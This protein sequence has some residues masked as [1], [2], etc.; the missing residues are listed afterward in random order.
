MGA[1]IASVF[2][3]AGLEVVAI[4]RTPETLDAGIG[5]ISKSLAAAVKRGAI[6]AAEAERRRA[7]ITPE[8]RL[9]AVSEVDLV[10]EA[11]S[12]DMAIKHGIF[13]EAGRLAPSGAILATN[14]SYLDIDALA[15]A[16]GRAPDVCGMHFF[17]PASAMRLVEVIRGAR[18]A[19]DVLATMMSL[20]RRIGKLPILAGTCEGF[21]VNRLL[22]KRSR[23]GFFM[24]E[25]G[26]SPDRIDRVLQGF[27]FPMGPYA[28]ADLAGIDV[29]YAARQARL[30]RLSARE[31]RADFVD[32]LFERGRYGQKTGA[33]WYRYDENRKAS[34]DPQTAE[35]LTTHA[36]RHGIAP[37]TI[38]DHEILERCLFAMVNE[39]ARL[40]EEGVV[41]R[42]HEVDV[43]MVSGIGFPAYTGGPMWWADEIG[44]ANVHAAILR[45]RDIVGADYWTPSPLLERLAATGGRFYEAVGAA[46]NMA[47]A[48]DTPGVASAA[49]S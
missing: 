18:T 9:A 14:T 37:R 38:D 30:D 19:P 27:G 11:A 34:S 33:G 28:L 25:E 48:T 32:Q 21:V 44:L 5:L 10:I 12:E 6:D 22:A 49:A 24:L 13:A 15:E 47:V 3:A 39:G 2:A 17:N 36:E 8:T 31:R 26:A 29:Q 1:G 16:S 46:V 23:E 40:I 43:A 45:Y 35:L 7:R 42:P 20:G 41:P 4:A